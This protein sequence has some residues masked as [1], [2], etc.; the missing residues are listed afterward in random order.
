MGGDK[1]TGKKGHGETIDFLTESLYRTHPDIVATG[2]QRILLERILPL[3]EQPTLTDSQTW[4]FD[5]STALAHTAHDL[6]QDAQRYRGRLSKLLSY[7]RFVGYT[8]ETLSRLSITTAEERSQEEYNQPMP[9]PFS[10]SFPE[11]QTQRVAEREIE[12]DFETRQTLRELDALMKQRETLP[13]Y[14]E[15]LVL[16]EEDSTNEEN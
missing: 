16:L 8:P 13:S 12:E 15:S 14:E 9:I 7:L 3:L 5:I 1:E 10:I 11:G 2:V 4:E 6:S